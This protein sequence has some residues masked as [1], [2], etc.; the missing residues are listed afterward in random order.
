MSLKLK[1]EA[2][3]KTICPCLITCNTGECGNIVEVIIGDYAVRRVGNNEQRSMAGVDVPGVPGRAWSGVP[4][5][6]QLPHSLQE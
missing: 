3:N 4:T 2:V 5:S 6:R 1:P